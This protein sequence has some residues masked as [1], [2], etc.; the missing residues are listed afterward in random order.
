MSLG[1]HRVFDPIV[2]IYEIRTL[3][4]GPQFKQSGLKVLVVQIKKRKKKGR[5]ELQKI[6]SF[7]ISS[8]TFITMRRFK[9]VI[10]YLVLMINYKKSLSE[11]NGD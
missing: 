4:G 3:F 9:D 10:I 11:I 2:S 8:L 1:G 6:I 7:I 5:E